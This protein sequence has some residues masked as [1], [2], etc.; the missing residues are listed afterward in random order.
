[1]CET[2]DEVHKQL[3]FLHT[4]LPEDFKALGTYQDLV[5]HLS[6]F[7]DSGQSALDLFVHL[8][9]DFIDNKNRFE[10]G[11][12]LACASCLESTKLFEQKNFKQS[13]DSF[14]TALALYE[15][16]KNCVENGYYLEK[17]L[18][19]K[20]LK[21]RIEAARQGGLIKAEKQYDPIKDEIIRL[22]KEKCPEGGWKNRTVAARDIV[23]DI[24]DFQEKLEPRRPLSPTNLERTIIRWISKDERVKP[25]FEALKRTVV[26]K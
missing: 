14:K 2:V 20:T 11:I 8:F 22:L 18:K 25:A 6:Q 3:D 21:K 1:M 12:A 17:K 23:N 15:V 7:L 10:Y 9:P 4:N 26:S 5:D 19:K 16:A 24:N 13:D